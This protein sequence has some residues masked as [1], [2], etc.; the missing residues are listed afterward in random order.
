LFKISA[1]K[2][3]IKHKKEKTMRKLWTDNVVEIEIRTS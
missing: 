3:I 2:N 1:A